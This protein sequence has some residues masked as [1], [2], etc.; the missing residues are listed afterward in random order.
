[1][2]QRDKQIVR[3]WAKR[4]MEL[5]QS[6]EQMRMNQRMKDTNDLKI[7]RPPVLIDEIPW[8]QMDIDGELKCECEDGGARGAE[9]FFRT[10]ST[11]E[12][13]SVRTPCSSPSGACGWQLTPRVPV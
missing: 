7:T 2:N 5:A 8:Y 10:A 11:G 9:Y 12:S 1:M 3:D 4:Y 6:D 13:T